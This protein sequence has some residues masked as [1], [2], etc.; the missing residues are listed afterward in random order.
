MRGRGTLFVGVA[1]GGGR[2][3][4][5]SCVGIYGDGSTSVATGH[6][7]VLRGC[8]DR[9]CRDRATTRVGLEV[10]CG[11][12]SD[13]FAEVVES[14]FLFFGTVTDWHVAGAVTCEYS[15]LL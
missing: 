5:T 14:K 4:A 1:V 9:N 10:T 15:S 2:S 7:L 13:I 6:S 11:E 8:D 12:L 3:A